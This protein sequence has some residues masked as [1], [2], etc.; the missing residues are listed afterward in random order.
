MTKHVSADDLDEKAQELEG[1]EASYLRERG[2]EYRCD[3][4][5][6][7]WLWIKRI[8]DRYLALQPDMA[9]SIQRALDLN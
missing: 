1:M 2:W 6:A 7:Y 9:I 4:P 3:F 8:G 5:G